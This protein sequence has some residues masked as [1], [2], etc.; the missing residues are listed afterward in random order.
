MPQASANVDGSG[1]V[2]P[3]PMTLGSSSIGATTSEIASV[4]VRPAHAA[5]RRPPLMPDRCL[6]TQLS[7]SMARPSCM[8][9]RVICCFS[10]NVTPGTGRHSSAEAPPDS[11]TMSRPSAGTPLQRR[12][13]HQPRP[14]SRRWA[15]GVRRCTTR[16]RRARGARRG[17][18]RRSR[19]RATP[20]RAHTT[21][22]AWRPTP[23]RRRSACRAA[24]PR[25]ARAYPAGRGAGG[26]TPTPTRGRRR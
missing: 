1:T 14:R 21:A 23:C 9:A 22:R 19:A 4:S 26:S 6:R 3:E 16:H 25:P 8:S 15:S 11:S 20:A 24:P 7:S 12:A 10:A 17:S 13:T 18:R 5:A 2:G